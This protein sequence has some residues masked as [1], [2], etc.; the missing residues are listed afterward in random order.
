MCIQF[1]ECVSLF[2]LDFFVCFIQLMC[3]NSKL[4][5]EPSY[6]R[7]YLFQKMFRRVLSVFCCFEK[8]K[9]EWLKWRGNVSHPQSRQWAVSC[10]TCLAF[11][12]KSR[13]LYKN[14]KI[15]V[16][17]LLDFTNWCSCFIL[18][19]ADYHLIWMH[20]TSTVNIITTGKMEINHWK[21]GLLA[22][23][24]CPHWV[25]LKSYLFFQSELLS[26]YFTK[27]FKGLVHPKRKI[28]SSFMYP[29][30]RLL[31]I[32]KTRWKIFLKESWEISVPLL[33]VHSTISKG[34]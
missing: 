7:L 27:H 8:K 14:H 23:F 32:F 2:P 21:M 24:F 26:K 28:W 15:M 13:T 17:G 20:W 1:N 25:I 16:L 4:N 22:S 12:F 3:S 10:M 33:K 11:D 9:R 30:S 29:S 19:L 31:F 18:G 6:F 34:S 5:K